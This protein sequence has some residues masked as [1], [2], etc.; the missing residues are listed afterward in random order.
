MSMLSGPSQRGLSFL[1][2]IQ[3]CAGLVSW[4]RGDEEASW[5]LVLTGDQM[6]QESAWHGSEHSCQSAVP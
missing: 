6:L 5:L 4:S 3:G 2:H 1:F